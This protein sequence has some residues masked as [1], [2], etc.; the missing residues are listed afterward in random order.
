MNLTVTVMSGSA[1]LPRELPDLIG[2][3]NITP[4]TRRMLEDQL[5]DYTFF[6]YGT[7]AARDGVQNPI[8]FRKDLF[9]LH[10]AEQF[11]LSDTPWLPGTRFVTDQTEVPRCC[12]AALLI[13]RDDFRLLRVYNTETDTA[14]LARVQGASLILSRITEDE[15]KYPGTPVVLMGDFHDGADGKTNSAVTKYSYGEL[16]LSAAVAGCIYTNL[17]AESEGASVVRAEF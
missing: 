13:K 17:P 6:G 14:P 11:W 2:F 8:A 1:A 12:T 3:Q 7:S 10:G 9:A 16:K 15:A 4:E 5:P